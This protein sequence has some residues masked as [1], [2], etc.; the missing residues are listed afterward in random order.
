MRDTFSRF[1]PAEVVDQL[2]ADSGGDVRLGGVRRECTMLFSDIRG[3]TTYAETTPADEVVEVLNHYL[4]EMTD[5]MMDNGGT[6]V[7][8]LGDGI[9]A[10]FGAPLAQP[11]HA[12]RAVAAAREMLEVRLPRFNA[13]MAENG[14]G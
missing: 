3:F 14:L 9:I 1:V 6:L 8:Y 11:D 7:S 4:G 10:V 2:L 12:D 13:W 5:A